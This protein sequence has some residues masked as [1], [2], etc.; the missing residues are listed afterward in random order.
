M[1]DWSDPSDEPIMREACRAV[2]EEAENVAKRNGTYLPFVYSNY[3]SRD[4]DPLASYGAENVKKLKE[5]AQKYDPDGVF[6]R[7]QYDGWLLSR[8]LA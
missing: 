6:Q 1:A 4:Q 5:I 2:I 8:S 3:A 7:L